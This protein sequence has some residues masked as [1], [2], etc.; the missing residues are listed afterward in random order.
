MLTRHVTDTASRSCY[1]RHYYGLLI[2]NSCTR[3]DVM[4]HRRALRPLPLTST[5]HPRSSTPVR[6]SS[7]GDNE[8]NYRRCSGMSGKSVQRGEGTAS[9]KYIAAPRPPDRTKHP[10]PA[11][12]RARCH[13]ACAAP[14][15]T[16]RFSHTHPSPNPPIT[17]RHP[18]R[19][20]QPR[21]L[22]ARLHIGA[23][24]HKRAVWLSQTLHP[25]P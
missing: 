15:I 18:A 5:F 7:C 8:V 6:T 24:P 20:S 1:P 11:V 25:S 12:C 4:C 10:C 21:V 3:L 2:V 16:L 13:A 17:T 9:A 22:R 23:P 19:Q 14:L